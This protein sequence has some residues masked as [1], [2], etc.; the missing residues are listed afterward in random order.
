M[1][2]TVEDSDEMNCVT[3]FNVL[4]YLNKN[5]TITNQTKDV[6]YKLEDFKYIIDCDESVYN[7][8]TGDFYTAKFGEFPVKLTL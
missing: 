2:S 5:V 3:E 6:E 8:N 4:D 1:E 7:A